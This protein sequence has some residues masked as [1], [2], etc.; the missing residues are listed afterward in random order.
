V[1]IAAAIDGNGSTQF[2][3]DELAVMISGSAA[4]VAGM[5]A[6][7]NAASGLAQNSALPRKEMSPSRDQRSQQPE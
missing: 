5:A 4:V 6:L 2:G 1:V 7:D 3:E